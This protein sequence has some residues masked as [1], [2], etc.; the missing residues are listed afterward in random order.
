M[1]CI[2]KFSTLTGLAIYGYGPLRI[3]R[4]RA[5]MSKTTPDSA[6]HLHGSR[7]PGLGFLDLVLR[8][9][10]HHIVLLEVHRLHE[11]RRRRRVEDG[12]GAREVLERD[13][14]GVK[15]LRPRPRES[16]VIQ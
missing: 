11:A 12:L 15:D 16:L 6:A 3:A 2:A 1:Y 9:N 5:P 14:R 7:V 4:G 13:P 8:F 10:T